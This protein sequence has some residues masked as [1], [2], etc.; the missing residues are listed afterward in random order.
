MQTSSASK[1]S[2][3]TLKNLPQRRGF[4]THRRAHMHTCSRYRRARM[5]ACFSHRHAHERACSQYRRARGHACQTHRHARERACSPHRRALVRACPPHRRAPRA[6]LNF[7]LTCTTAHLFSGQ[8][9]TY[10]CLP[11]NRPRTRAHLLGKFPLNLLYGPPYLPCPKIR[12]LFLCR[13][14]RPLT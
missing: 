2:F 12:N 7:H 5:H 3:F 9:R 4:T 1:G 11:L 10:A 8:A 14:I 6:R 13:M